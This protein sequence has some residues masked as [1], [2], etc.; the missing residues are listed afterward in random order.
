MRCFVRVVA[1]AVL[2]LPALA[3]AQ[4]P[5]GPFAQLGLD[6]RDGF[7]LHWTEQSAEYGSGPR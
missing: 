7:L 2:L 6:M 3:P 4:G 5:G 1:L